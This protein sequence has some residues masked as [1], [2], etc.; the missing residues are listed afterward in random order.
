MDVTMLANDLTTIIAPFGPYLVRMGEQSADEA[1]RR[2]G[3]APEE[4]RRLLA[5]WP[6]G[7]GATTVA[8]ASGER[9]IAVGRDA[10]DSVLRTGDE[11]ADSD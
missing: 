1:G 2:L 7:T 3:E 10:I 5:A 6:A 4:V 11:V 9:S 8:A